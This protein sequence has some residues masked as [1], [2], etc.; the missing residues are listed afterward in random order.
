MGEITITKLHHASLLVEGSAARVLVDPGTL[1]PAPDLAE[2]DAVLVTHDHYDHADPTVLAAAVGRGI[3][4][5][6]P[7]DAVA[8]LR[9]AGVEEV[10]AGQSFTVGDL[11]ILAV[12][13]RHAAVHPEFLGP[14]NRAYFIGGRLFVTGDEF[15]IPPGPVEILATPVDAPWLRAADLIRYIRE[16]RPR[17]VLGLHDGLLNRDGLQVADAVLQS[18]LREGA[19]EVKRLPVG[20][21]VEL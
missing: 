1:A 15:A 9:I 4:V 18:L 8:R 16:I 2:V 5:W 21:R 19:K 6:A 7:P 11:D 10:E 12:G 14:T 17:V 13:D 20:G 3:P